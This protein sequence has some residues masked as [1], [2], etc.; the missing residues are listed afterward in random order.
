MPRHKS[1]KKR[2]KQSHKK[3]LANTISISKYRSAVK[4]YKKL[5]ASESGEKVSQSFYKVNSLASRAVKK[6]IIKPKTASRNLSKLYKLIKTEK[7]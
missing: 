7:R 1:A 2:K 3:N 6:G 4:E 5:A